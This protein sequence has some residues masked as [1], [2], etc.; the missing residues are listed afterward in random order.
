[1]ANKESI[2]MA[3]YLLKEL[4]K[5]N[6]KKIFPVDSEHSCLA[7][8]IEAHGRNKVDKLFITASGGPFRNFS[9]NQLKGITP[10]QASN[11]PTWKMGKKISIDSATLANKALEI[12]EASVLFDFPSNKIV[13]IINPTSQVHSLVNLKNGQTYAQI[14][15]PSMV[16]PI[17]NA[18]YKAF[19]FSYELSPLTSIFDFMGN[20]IKL[21]FYPMDQK[22][23]PMIRLGFE[24]LNSSKGSLIVFNA[25]NEIAVNKFCLGEINFLQIP[26]LVEKTLIKMGNQTLTDTFEDIFEIDRK[27]R[28][29]GEKLSK[30]F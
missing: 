24:C 12:I 17:M 22:K 29:I 1:M 14:S 10:L 6:N 7:E 18:I 21:E 9:L 15:Q 4:A 26:I 20:G 19:G 27:T 23:F 11:H 30:T 16:F 2:V 8:L 3:G 5:N 28:E 13:P 25:A